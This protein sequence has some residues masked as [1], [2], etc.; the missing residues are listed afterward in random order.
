[1]QPIFPTTY[2]TLSPQALADYVGKQYAFQDTSCQFIVRGVGDTYLVTTA[3]EQYI[4]RI[5][6][7]SHRTLANIQAEVTLLQI[8]QSAGVSVSYP[9]EDKEGKAIQALSAAEGTRHAVL[10]TYA[11]GRSHNIL[12]GYQLQQLG[13]EMAR[14]HT[15]SATIQLE[16]ERWTFDTTTTLDQPLAAVR[17]YFKE[18]P[19]TYEWLSQAIERVKKELSGIGQESIVSGYCHFDFLPK[20]FHF[21]A[22]DQI[23]LFDFDFFGRGWLIQDIMTFRQQ[24]LLDKAMQRLTAEQM[25]QAY[26]TF[27]KAYCEVRPLSEAEKAAIPWLGL[28]FWVFYMGFHLTH[29]QFYPLTQLHVLQ[30]RIA[31]IKKLV[32]EEWQKAGE[33]LP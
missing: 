25:E 10:F 4:L 24:L 13:K 33:V 26:S 7:P 27:L 29:D 28:G 9:V 5:Y 6:R 14:F 15:V 17:D 12:S 3:A 8:L 20:N 19:A 16:H 31:V 2:S 11:E 22:V 18:D 32:E 1:M 21:D 23:T 30:S